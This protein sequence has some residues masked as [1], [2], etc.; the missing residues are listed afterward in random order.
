MIPGEVGVEAER[1]IDRYLAELATHLPVA[2]RAAGDILDEL[3]ADLVEATW[4]R[5]GGEPDPARAAR[6]ACAEFGD[7][8]TVA[9]AFAPELIVGRCRRLGLTLLATGPLV[10]V[11]WLVAALAARPPAGG[12]DLW[13]AVPVLALLA[14]GA[15]ATGL[16]VLASG[17]LG[18]RWVRSS[19]VVATRAVTIASGVAGV[20]DVLLVLGAVLLVTLAGLAPSPWLGPAGAA[21]AARLVFLAITTARWRRVRGICLRIR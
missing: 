21:S 2:P 15:P 5:T 9:A 19:A 6:A 17:R 11:C 14:V 4:V 13:L 20:A 18:T 1:V 3:R 16:S 12:P 7:V 8:T 10:G